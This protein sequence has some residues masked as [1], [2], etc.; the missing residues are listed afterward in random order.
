MTLTRRLRM[1]VRRAAFIALPV[2]LL[3]VG[4]SLAGVLQGGRQKGSQPAPQHGASHAGTAPSEHAVHLSPGDLR[5]VGAVRFPTSCDPD[6]QPEFTRAVALLHSFFYDEARQAFT[7]VTQQ[8]PECGIAHWGVAMTWY[9]PVWTAPTDEEFQAGLAAME[10]ARAIGAKTQREMA[11]IAALATFFCRSDAG[12]DRAE[13]R[14]CPANHTERTRR[15]TEAMARLHDDHA[16]DDDAAAFYAL[17]LLGSAPPTDPAFENQLRA[18]TV[19]EEIWRENRNHP[20]VTHYLIHALDYPALAERGLAAAKVYADIAPWV[21]H[22]L[23]MPSHTFTRQ[24]LWDNSIDTNLASAQASRAHTAEHHPGT[25]SFEELHALD[26][27]VYAYLQTTRDDEAR[28]IVDRVAGIEKTHPEIDFVVAY[29]VGA[30]P[31]RFALE[32][33]AWAEAASLPIPPRRFWAEFPF[34]EAHL[35]FAHALGRARIGDL[36]G[37]RRAIERLGELRD[38]VTGPRFEYF[39]KHVD[40]QV[41]AASGWL[42]AAEGRHHAA[43]ETLRQAADLEDALGKHPVTPGPVFPVR[44]LLGHA[45]V[46]AGRPGEALEA[47]QASL[48]LSPGRFGAAY[49]AGLAAEQAGKTEVA[50]KY[51]REILRLSERGGGQRPELE[52]ALAY[53]NR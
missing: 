16:E 15:Y 3:G 8:D 27:A 9:H 4:M 38:A 24:G 22:A 41:Q 7:G 29:A 25:V 42:M 5:K 49:G 47:Y 2:L 52:H 6:A 37:S 48:Q 12:G 30:I 33:G 28:K 14:D 46:D 23:H 17:A 51:Y 53:L 26:Y 1:T 11:Y 40:V 10:A 21:P 44:E 19:L 45:L 35:E 39:R 32:R 43:L 20:G 31:A 50:R 13:D 36:S 34:A 18:A